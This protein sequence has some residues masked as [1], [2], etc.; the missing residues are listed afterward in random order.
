MVSLRVTRPTKSQLNNQKKPEE[1]K[2][3]NHISIIINII[4]IH[5]HSDINIILSCGIIKINQ[6][7]LIMKIDLIYSY[8]NSY[9][10]TGLI[11]S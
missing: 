11:I 5:D 3:Y 4:V 7:V 1:E 8:L 9:L 6:N 10:N 2:N